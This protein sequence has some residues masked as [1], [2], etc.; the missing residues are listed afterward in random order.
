MSHWADLVHYI[1]GARFP[2][3][4]VALGGTYVWK[5]KRNCP[6]SIEATLE[7]KEGMIVHFSTTFGNAKGNSRRIWGTRGTVDI[8]DWS[9][10]TV[11]GEGSEDPERIKEEHAVELVPMTPH[12]QNW[13]QCLRTRTP[14]HADIDAG[15][16]HAVACILADRAYVEGRRMVYDPEA[17]T[18]LPG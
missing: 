2:W 9:K 12:M 3:R 8:L 11:T 13:L 1:T 14:P 16:Q 7:Y 17:R 4:A 5:D 18:I 6:D 10:A 15:Y